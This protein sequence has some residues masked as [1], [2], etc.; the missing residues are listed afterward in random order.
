MAVEFKYRSRV[1]NDADV[2]FVR[3]FIGQNPTAS[4]RKLSI[5]LCQEWNWV[6][7]NGVLCDMV[8]RSMMLQMHRC[9]IIELPRV[10]QVA[11]NPL[12]VR[13]RPKPPNVETTE[14]DGGLRSI[15]PLE[16]VQVRRSKAEA[17]FNG[18]ME[19]YHY[20]GY[21]QPVGEHLKYLIYASGRPVAAMAWSSAPRHLG[22]RDRFIGWSA[23]QRRRN[24]RF[25]AYNS[26]FLILPWV[27]VPHLA[28]HI[29][30]QM[31]KMLP[32]DWEKLYGHPVYFLETFIDPQRFKG[33]CYR[34]ANWIVL[35]NTTGRGHKDQTKKPNRPIKEILG[36]PLSKQFRRLLCET[37]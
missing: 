8:C 27:R 17:I 33:V 32:C 13:T 3:Q 19:Q 15:Q 34:A 9:G 1:L 18:L 7:P 31:A 26:R 36:Y 28:S 30:G 11:R 10:R 21:T 14:L 6:Q 12:T 22:P 24:I 37:V 2:S 25:I 35:G 4:R 20:L 5:L 16:F 23:Q 29:L